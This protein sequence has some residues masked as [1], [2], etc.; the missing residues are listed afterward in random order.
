MIYIICSRSWSSNLVV[1]TEDEW[2]IAADIR[3]GQI[4]CA[5][6][7]AMS[8]LSYRLSIFERRSRLHVRDAAAIALLL[9]IS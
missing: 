8:Y 9:F 5:A 7:Q 3:E 4:Q 2:Q 6:H 1:P